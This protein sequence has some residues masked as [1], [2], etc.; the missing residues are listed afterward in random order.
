MPESFYHASAAEL[1]RNFKN[2]PAA[3]KPWVYWYW[4][5]DHISKTGIERDLA[6]MQEAGISAALIG[7]IHL[8]PSVGGYGEVSALT[9]EWWDHLRFAI[10]K[11]ADYNI[12][13]GLF[14]S[15]GWSQSGGPWVQPEQSMRYL[16]SQEYQVS[17]RGSDTLPASL[18]L[19]K[20][21]GFAQDV[22]VLAFRTPAR[23]QE[24]L[25]NQQTS[26]TVRYQVAEEAVE[27]KQ[28][29][30]LID[31]NPESVYS[32]PVEVLTQ[33]ASDDADHWQVDF[34]HERPFRA[35]TLEIYPQ[36]QFSAQATLLAKNSE[37][38]FD[39]IR[40]FSLQR[41]RSMPAIGPE[42]DAPIVINF[43][44]VTAR[45]Y[46]L[47]LTGFN[48]SPKPEQIPGIKDIVV[49]SGY[50]LERYVEKK[51]AKVHPTP[52]P[53][54][55]SYQWPK[56]TPES[57]PDMAISA[58][59]VLDIT[60]FV[61]GDRLTWQVP[62]G[63][64]TVVHYFMRSTG[65]TNGPSS[66]NA[67]G[68]EIDKLSKAIAQFHFDEYVGKVLN[69]MTPFERRALKY[70]VVDSYEQGAQNWTDG[71]SEKFEQQF[72]Y[73]P[74]PYLPVYTGRI[75]NSAEQSE[76]FLWDVRRMVADRVSYEY[77]A[78]L[79]ERAHQHG[80]KLWLEN[81]GHW[82]FPGEFLQ[83]GGQADIVSGE[84]WASGNLGAIELKAASSAAHIYGH[85]TVMSE[86]FTAGRSDGFKN[87]PWNFKKRGDW[88]FVE[89]INH[90][91]LHV[92][93]QQAYEDKFPGVNAWFG[94]EFNRNN[95]WFDFMG[96]WL[97]YIQRANYM[98]QQ[99]QYVADILFYIGEDVPKMTGALNPAVPDGYSYDFINAEVILNGLTVK[100][101]LF[102]LP[103]GMTFKLLVLPDLPYMRP[104]VL[105]KISQLVAEGGAVYGPKPA[106][107]PSL[108]NY[109]HADENVWRMA[110]KL[111]QQ[112][113]G[114]QVTQAKYG[115]G[116]VFYAVDDQ[117]DLAAVMQQLGVQQDVT[118][119][120]E[121]VIWSHRSSNTHEI[122]FIANQSEAEVK[123]QASF[124]LDEHMGRPQL[125]N[126][127]TGE[128][129]AVAQY[130]V[131]NE[132][133]TLPIKLQGLESAFVV[134]EKSSSA[135]FTPGNTENA[136]QAIS[137]AGLGG[138]VWLPSAFDQQGNIVLDI[139]QNGHYQVLFNDGQ[140]REIKVDDLPLE[141]R[142]NQP[143][144][145][146]F[147]ADRDVA[148]H[149][150]LEKLVSLTEL[151][152]LAL[153]HYSGA[154]VYRNQFSLEPDML[155]SD[156]RW[157]LDLGQVGVI[158]RVRVNG[159][160]FGEVWSRPLKVDI[161]GALKVGSNQ[162]EVEVATTWVNR[163]VGDQQYPG[164]FPD[165]SAPK[166]FETEI[167][168]E[169]KITK[170]SPLQ[171]AGLIGPVTIR[172]VRKVSL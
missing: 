65:T 120:P 13:I 83:Y 103:S 153:K 40:S 18:T 72:G 139:P 54:H 85:K 25:N 28:V 162:L 77:A 27:Q 145:L 42:H 89:G 11:A 136:V 2:P 124:R 32:F 150:T 51:L 58:E 165:S 172:P 88:S 76:R 10:E 70:V 92:Y 26:V 84:F 12:D 158:A 38:Q 8:N 53:K 62:D 55:D 64:W 170:D 110:D 15:P 140:T 138:P 59:Q 31:G 116:Q 61:E 130:Q 9:D 93:I 4:I 33:N 154:V 74:I 30:A 24:R 90:T 126:A 48:A 129:K 104:E 63:Q 147:E 148:I 132:R 123:L 22:K 97:D 46:R 135:A 39:V 95:T 56:P 159:N 155:R 67:K 47:R 142:L 106:H 34:A 23:E 143:W 37:G 99:G 152:P 36:H 69:T 111:W 163:L 114:R 1:K 80:L 14:N 82:G 87:H 125:W 121:S 57:E 115:L 45:E 141:Q 60:E 113:D 149:H 100:D 151:E 98:M 16:D 133:L 49:S 20:P 44:A 169:S 81:Y 161:T 75:V 96:S 91:L 78:G 160:D 122:Y 94:S 6:A 167:T 79:R 164:Q 144:K 41:P 107:S 5:N 101:G 105:E 102:E 19:R 7:I 109:P 68:P 108:Q 156:Q 137:Q 127:V 43:P 17:G 86:S 21:E 146:T 118:G 119:L 29:T 168:F 112:I 157:V 35:R 117:A 50:K 73:S 71:F 52:Q 171:P 131:E 3:V 66:K 128:T 134:F 166:A